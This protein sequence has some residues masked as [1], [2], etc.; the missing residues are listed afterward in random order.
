MDAVLGSNF[1]SVGNACRKVANPPNDPAHP[2][3]TAQG[4]PTDASSSVFIAD[5]ETPGILYVVSLNYVPIK[6][7]PFD[8]A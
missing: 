5:S 2:T 7:L 1:A 8:D 3:I 6:V 4:Y